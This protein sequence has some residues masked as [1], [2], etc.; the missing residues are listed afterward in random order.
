MRNT[1]SFAFLLVYCSFQAGLQFAPPPGFD[2]ISNY[3]GST[4]F[5]HKDLVPLQICWFKAD[6][7][8]ILLK[9]DA[10]SPYVEIRPHT[11]IS[12]IV[13]LQQFRSAS[14]STPLPYDGQSLHS[15]RPARE[16]P[17]AAWRYYRM[18]Q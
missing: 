14:N 11:P 10:A 8:G 7:K 4:S 18:G 3:D 2:T 17:E 16:V 13:H 15:S 1:H 12:R 9:H 6:R 5:S